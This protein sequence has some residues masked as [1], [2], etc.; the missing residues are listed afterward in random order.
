MPTLK[1]DASLASKLIELLA[2]DDA[3]RETFSRDPLAALAELGQAPS[4]ELKT[5]VSICCSNVQLADKEKIAA[6][7]EQIKSML[8]SGAS[9]S[10]PMLD[11]N[12]SGGR[13]LK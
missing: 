2:S 6:A 4:D 7:Q 12:L 5:F 8:T 9:Q 11:A 1:L 10:V 3:F 13:T